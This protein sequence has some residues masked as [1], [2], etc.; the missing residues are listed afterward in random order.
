ME[1]FRWC[2]IKNS[3][4]REKL[5]KK[6][7]LKNKHSDKNWWL[8]NNQERIKEIRRNDMKRGIFKRVQGIHYEER[9]SRWSNKMSNKTLVWPQWTW[10][11]SMPMRSPSPW[12]I[13]VSLLS[14]SPR[15]TRHCGHHQYDEPPCYRGHHHQS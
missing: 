11:V 12:F 2:L 3:E 13:N 15:C 8:I 14:P 5:K 10:F 1:V 9:L 6:I 7:Y 4:T